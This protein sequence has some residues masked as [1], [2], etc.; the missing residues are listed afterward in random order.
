MVT[1]AGIASK[2]GDAFARL[3]P[4]IPELGKLAASLKDIAVS[5]NSQ[6]P[7]IKKQFEIIKTTV[8]AIIKDFNCEAVSRYDKKS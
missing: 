5:V 2:A 4:V 6:S 7:E 8:D 1:L 3:Q